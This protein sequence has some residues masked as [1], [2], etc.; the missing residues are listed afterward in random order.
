MKKEVRGV[1]LR[2]HTEPVEEEFASKIRPISAI[3]DA[4]KI[5]REQLALWQWISEYYMCTIGEVMSAALPGSLDKRLV[6]PP[7]R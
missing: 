1:V 6:D 5:S 7:K 3:I 2:T 4:P